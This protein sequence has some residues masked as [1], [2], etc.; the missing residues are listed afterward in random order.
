MDARVMPHA[1]QLSP[2]II[3]DKHKSR[4]LS[5]K[6]EGS[7]NRIIGMRKYALIFK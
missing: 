6:L 1:G 4:P 2:R 5:K 7:R 3:F